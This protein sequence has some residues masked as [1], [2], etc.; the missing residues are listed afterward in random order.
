MYLR[1]PWFEATKISDVSG[2][3]R[4]HIRSFKDRADMLVTTAAQIDQITDYSIYK[5]RLMYEG[6]NDHY[7]KIIQ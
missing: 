6:Y 3:F 5:H 7:V 2:T 4:G 1:P